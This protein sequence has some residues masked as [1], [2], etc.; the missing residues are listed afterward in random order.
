MSKE[1]AGIPPVTYFYGE[2]AF[3]MEKAVTDLLEGLIEELVFIV[4]ILVCILGKLKDGL[5]I[6]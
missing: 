2:D 3:L 4:E 6:A 1:T 5:L